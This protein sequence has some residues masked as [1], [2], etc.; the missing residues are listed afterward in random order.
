[1]RRMNVGTG[2]RSSHTYSSRRSEYVGDGKR[3]PS[4]DDIPR[5]RRPRFGDIPS[6]ILNPFGIGIM[7]SDEEER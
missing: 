5:H 1:M 7:R 4:A 2:W 6:K 3:V